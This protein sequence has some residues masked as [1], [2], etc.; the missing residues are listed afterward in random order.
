[1]SPEPFQHKSP[2]ATRLRRLVLAPTVAMSIQP[3]R[4]LNP[5]TALTS[6]NGSIKWQVKITEGEVTS[7]TFQGGT[8]KMFAFFCTLVGDDPT[9]YLR[10]TFKNSSEHAVQEIRNKYQDGKMFLMSKVA[11]DA[12]QKPEY[13]SSPI[14]LMVVMSPKTKFE[15]I[16]EG[17]VSLAKQAVPAARIEDMVPIFRMPDFKGGKYDVAG[18]VRNGPH[19]KRDVNTKQGSTRNAADF[20][21]VQMQAPGGQMRG[22]EVTAWGTH[23][24]TL[25]ANKGKF[26]TLFEL[27]VKSQATGRVTIETGWNARVVPWGPMDERMTAFANEVTKDSASPLDLITTSWTPEAGTGIDTKG[28]QPLVNTSFLRNCNAGDS[29]QHTWQINGCFV[30]LPTGAIHTTDNNR[31]WFIAYLRDYSGAIE[32]GI[33]EAAALSLA[34]LKTKQDFENA[35][36]NGS[37]TFPRCNVRGARGVREKGE[38]RFTV[39]A[40]EA[41][42][43]VV[44]LTKEAENLYNLVN[45]FGRGAGGIVGTAIK[46]LVVDPFVGLM[47]GML[48]VAKALLLVKGKDKSVMEMLQGSRKMSTVVECVFTGPADT[49]DTT[50]YKVVAF[51]QEDRVSDFKFDKGQ[52]MI[53]ATGKNRLSNGEIEIVAEAITIVQSDFVPTVRSCLQKERQ[54]ALNMTSGGVLKEPSP[55]WLESPPSKGKKC[56]LIHRYP[57]DPPMDGTM[58]ALGA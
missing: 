52:A 34:G 55:P 57:S 24:D 11:F 33:N 16:M 37:L 42:E 29:K 53:L 6:S 25:A 45:M 43:D 12:K 26:V 51:C 58:A 1:M 22:M 49:S 23:V 18:F 5:Q 44:P 35:Y 40:C 15:P 30:D 4:L 13:I 39:T 38:F 48:P 50:V 27:E 54:L 14:K 19:R 47:A 28:D 20:E 32:V 56:K 7:F 31:L 10:G 21:V 17:S 3:L 2:R 41:Q 36:A 46:D 8:K 9:I